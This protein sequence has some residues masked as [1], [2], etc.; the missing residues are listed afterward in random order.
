MIIFQGNHR[1]AYRDPACYFKD[2]IFHLFFH[3]SIPTIPETHGDATLAFLFTDDFKN[4]FY[5]IN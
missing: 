5:D 3:G 2:G 1:Y 4:F